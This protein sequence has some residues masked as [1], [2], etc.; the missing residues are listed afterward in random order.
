M[1]FSA[2]E[3]EVLP[4]TWALGRRHVG[5]RIHF[6]TSARAPW[7]TVLKRYSEIAALDAELGGGLGKRNALRSKSPA[8]VEE[9]KAMI[10]AFLS[11]LAGNEEHRPALLRFLDA[12]EDAAEVQLPA[13]SSLLVQAVKERALLYY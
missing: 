13:A 8:L 11:T 6:R 2:G 5:Y 3:T 7:R 9:R 10:P 12:A 1:E 4:K